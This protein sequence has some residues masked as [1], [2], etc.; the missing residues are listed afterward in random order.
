MAN[1]TP[2]QDSVSARPPPPRINGYA[3]IGWLDKERPVFLAADKFGRRC[4]IKQPDPSRFT[5][6]VEKRHPGHP[7][8]KRM[9]EHYAHE[10]LRQEYT[11]LTRISHPQVVRP[12]AFQSDPDAHMVLQYA[13]PYAF[14]D[15]QGLG[16]AACISAIVVV[17]DT[18]DYL[19]KKE[20]VHGDLRPKNIFLDEQGVLRIGDFGGAESPSIKNPLLEGLAVGT[21]HYMPP[22]RLRTKSPTKEAD[23]YAVGAMGIELLTGKLP[24]PLKYEIGPAGC[25]IRDVDT[26]HPAFDWKHLKEEYGNFGFLLACAVHSSPEVRPSMGELADAGREYLKRQGV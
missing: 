10:R 6:I 21:P 25:R 7:D 20:I 15:L 16:P 26:K 12:L 13:G 18:V 19:H 2:A 3:P 9:A 4:V 1:I 23:A 8:K 22:E 24:Y 14:C 5:G 11:L 17:A